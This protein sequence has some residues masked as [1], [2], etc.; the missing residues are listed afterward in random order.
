MNLR[1]NLDG[2]KISELINSMNVAIDTARE[3]LELYKNLK[4]GLLQQMFI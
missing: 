4:K 2:T 3:E 1:K